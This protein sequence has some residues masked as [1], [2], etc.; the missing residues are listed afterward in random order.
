MNK[1]N[2]K[3][4]DMFSMII[5]PLSQDISKMVALVNVT[6]TRARKRTV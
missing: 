2:A 5:S 6:A 3:H 1:F 4:K